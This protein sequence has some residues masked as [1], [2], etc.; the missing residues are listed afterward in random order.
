MRKRVLRTLAACPFAV[1]DAQ[2]ALRVQQPAPGLCA[3]EA[4]RALLPPT[5]PCAHVQFI[6]GSYGRGNDQGV[7]RE[8]CS[9][10]HRRGC[11]SRLPGRRKCR[12][13]PQSL[14]AGRMWRLPYAKRSRLGGNG[15]SEPRRPQ[16]LERR[17]GGPGCLRRRRDAVVCRRSFIE[18]DPAARSLGRQRSGRRIVSPPNRGRPRTRACRSPQC[19]SFNT[20]YTASATSTVPS[21]DSSDRSRQGQ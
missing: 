1:G 12:H 19:G 16:T 5:R 6:S 17:R 9:D 15:R 2:F 3:G 14:V 8:G 7:S 13:R 21:P 18:R 10:V 20:P 4:T 11:R